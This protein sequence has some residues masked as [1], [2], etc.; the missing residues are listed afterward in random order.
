MFKPKTKFLAGMK[1]NYFFFFFVQIQSN[2]E[3]INKIYLYETFIRIQNLSVHFFNLKH[4][5]EVKL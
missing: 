5:F 2:C 3:L 1:K 4:L